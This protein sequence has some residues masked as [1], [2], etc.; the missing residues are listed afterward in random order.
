MLKYRYD[1]YSSRKSDF[2]VPTLVR[3]SRRKKNCRRMG[4]SLR[5]SCCIVPAATSVVTHSPPCAHD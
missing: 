3:H 2:F 4:R 1:Y 5:E